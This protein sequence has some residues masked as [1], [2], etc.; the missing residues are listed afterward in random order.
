MWRGGRQVAPTCGLS[1]GGRSRPS[2]DARRPDAGQLHSCGVEA[3]LHSPRFHD[4]PGGSDRP[5]RSYS[6]LTAAPS[7]TRMRR[8]SAP[9]TIERYAS[10]APDPNSARGAPPLPLPHRHGRDRSAVGQ[11]TDVV[12]GGHASA[13]GGA[14]RRETS[15]GSATLVTR[16]GPLR[17]CGTRVRRN[18]SPIRAPASR[19]S[20]RVSAHHHR[21]HRAGAADDAPRGCGSA[22]RR[23]RARA[24]FER[25][26]PSAAHLR[27]VGVVPAPVS[28]G[29]TARLD[30]QHRGGAPPLE[31]RRPAAQP[32]SQC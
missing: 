3:R 7:R 31:P 16:I 32:A 18:Y 20:Q 23:I 13:C 28:A 30:Q 6:T 12:V 4:A 25:P 21:V 15:S 26:S 22:Y 14:N 17:S 10:G 9:V 19:H 8:T 5:R 1:T 11:S 29:P 24:R 27:A 2:T